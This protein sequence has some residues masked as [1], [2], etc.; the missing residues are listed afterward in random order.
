MSPKTTGS[1]NTYPTTKRT[2]HVSTSSLRPTTQTS[3][4]PGP[5]SKYR[6]MVVGGVDG[7][8]NRL[9]DVELIEHT[10][11]NS[12]CDK[13][14]SF[15]YPVIE[16]V[17]ET[18]DKNT[19]ICGGLSDDNDART[20]CYQYKDTSQLP[21]HYTWHAGPDRLSLFRYRSSSITLVD[22]RIWVFGGDGKSGESTTSEILNPEGQFEFGSGLPEPTQ[23]HCTANI[24]STHVFF[25]GNGFDPQT[26]AY[27]VDTTKEPFNFFKLPP[28]LY[29]RF[30][31]ACSVI[32][33]PEHPNDYRYTKLFVAGGNPPDD[34]MTE[35]YSFMD[36]KWE[37]GPVLLRG[38]RF[39]G[40]ISNQEGYHY[41]FVLI[42][43]EDNQDNQ[44]RDDIMSYNFVTN[45]FEYMPGKLTTPRGDFGAALHFSAEEC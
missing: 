6:I 45:S 10:K 28:M 42:G 25:A 17:S 14:Q 18:Y 24:N 20:E 1:T 16:T 12:N 32:K 8:G 3:T 7:Q 26:Q 31:A 9:S 22:G 30:G 41:S 15:P 19:L 38:F 43:G 4:L 23:S 44:Y 35:T 21:G 5:T 33:D 11:K 27:I 36:D 34:Q 29:K 39:G 37:I 40:Y 2:T 13:P